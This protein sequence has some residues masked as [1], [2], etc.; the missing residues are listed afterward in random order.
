MSTIVTE[1]L[2]SPLVNR[3]LLD[4]SSCSAPA[5]GVG[6][7]TNTYYD[8]GHTLLCCLSQTFVSQTHLVGLV[9]LP[10]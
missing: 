8:F 7:F 2:G 6:K 5:L 3:G 10:V 1:T 4:K 9:L